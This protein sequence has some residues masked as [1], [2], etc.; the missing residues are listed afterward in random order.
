MLVFLHLAH[1][2]LGI[3]ETSKSF[4]LECYK[5]TKN[6]PAEEKF[7]M[8][9]QIRGAVLSAHLNVA[10]GCSR[11][12]LS[13]RKHFYK[14][15]RSM[16]IGVDTAFTTEFSLNSCSDTELTPPGEKLIKTFKI[17]SGM[18][19]SNDTHY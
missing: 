6:F 8:I 3:F 17:Q 16:V 4:V 5:A 11:K 18:I 10:E 12:S 19:G 9:L 7:A 2:R 15:A 14:V 13:K 1:T